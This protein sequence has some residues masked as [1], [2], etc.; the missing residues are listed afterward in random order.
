MHDHHP[1]RSSTP[2]LSFENRTQG[3]SSGL[4][5]HGGGNTS[6]K[7]RVVDAVTGAAVDVLAVKG[8]GYDMAT[9]PPRGFSLVRLDRCLEITRNCAEMADA[10][11]VRELR[12]HLLDH[13][14]PN[15]SVEA[16]L[17]AVLPF[18]HVHHSHA[19]AVLAL[20]DSADAEALCRSVFGDRFL[21][22]PYV[23]PGFPLARRVHE[24]YQ[25]AAGDGG[26]AGA[27]LDGLILLRH[28]IVTWGDTAE[29]A[30]T[31]HI[32]AVNAAE[33]HIG[34]VRLF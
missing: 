33:A 2:F 19:D 14:C 8:S 34:Q 15:P 26:G 10:A 5:L 7:T 24:A 6:V 20:A 12:T 29:D 23:M 32:A 13:A 27:E 28:G 11:M 9:I 4:V 31:K 21:V 17:H 3:A 25:A 1:R 30:Y 18:K 16:L 22:L